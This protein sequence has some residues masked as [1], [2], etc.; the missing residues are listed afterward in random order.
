MYCSRNTIY[1]CLFI[2][3]ALVIL[4]TWTLTRLQ[5]QKIRVLRMQLY[6]FLAVALCFC[7]KYVWK[8]FRVLVNKGRTLETVLKFTILVLLVMAQASSICIIFFTQTDPSWLSFIATFSLG[9]ILLTTFCIMVSDVC[10]F[11]YQRMFCKRR[12]GPLNRVEIKIRSILSLISALII[13]IIGTMCVNNLTVERVVVPVKGLHPTLNGTTIVQI[14]DLHLGPFNGKSTLTS[15]VEKINKL[16]SDIVVITGDLVD[17]SVEALH[18]AVKPLKNLKAKYG[19]Y[20]ITGMY[21]HTYLLIKAT[22]QYTY[23]VIGFL[24]SPLV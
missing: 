6:V 17:S 9:S 8:R 12:I 24:S 7:S 21:L 1:F 3:I 10:S 16:K 4:E 18:G 22:T 13:I 2:V 19:V 11:I 5:P 15:I 20:Y 23:W 14:S